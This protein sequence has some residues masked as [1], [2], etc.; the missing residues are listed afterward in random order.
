MDNNAYTAPIIQNNKEERD[1]EIVDFILTVK[2]SEQAQ[3][4]LFFTFPIE[5]TSPVSS[6]L[7]YFKIKNLKNKKN[8]EFLQR[9]TA[10]KKD[11]DDNT[12][13]L[14]GTVIGEYKGNLYVNFDNKL[15]AECIDD[16]NFV[17]KKDTSNFTN[18]YNLTC[19]EQI[20]LGFY[21]T[22][23]NKYYERAEKIYLAKRESKSFIVPDKPNLS[24]NREAMWLAA[25][26]SSEII[27]ASKKLVNVHMLTS[28][29]NKKNK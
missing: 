6:G 19:F 24:L 2:N 8:L 26:L 7:V 14:Y 4:W 23:H 29:L 13:K 18:F 28:I 3:S 12:E 15:E 5:P 1:K 17:I 22:L 10:Q 21:I 9:I 16:A 11:R 20:F 27:D 25:D